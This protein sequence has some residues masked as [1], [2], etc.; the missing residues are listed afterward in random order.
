MSKLER[1]LLVCPTF[2]PGDMFKDWLKAFNDQEAKP[3]TA[4]IIDSASDDGF[5]DIAK[6]SGFIVDVI[7]RH[8]FNHGGTR[9]KAVDKNEPFDYVIF[10][11][12]DAILSNVDSLSN[13]LKPF[14]DSRVAAVCGRQL[15][16]KKAASIEKHARLYNYSLQSNVKSIND[17]GDFGLKTAFISNSFAAYRVSVLN[18]MGGFPENVIFGED[19]YVAAKMLNAGYKIAYAADACVYHSHNY[20]LIQEMKRYFDM[21]VFHAREPWIRKELGGAEGEG[22]KFVI[23]EFRYLL[24]NAFWRIPEGIL[25]TL[26]RYTGFRLGLMEKK[27]PIWL[28]KRLAMN[29]GYFN[30]L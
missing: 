26:L 22:V 27:L 17:V 5:V 9:Q 13:I 8:Q 12:Q 11:T 10:L 29:H 18:E 28:R 25:R 19:M 2:N 24:K 23:S 15:P 3:A 21:G 20:S 1:T 30:S 7:D 4:L 16:R 14:N 6:K